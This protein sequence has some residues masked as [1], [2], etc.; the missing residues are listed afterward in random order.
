MLKSGSQVRVEI[1]LI[2][3]HTKFD[4]CCESIADGVL[5]NMW[6]KEQ[7]SMKRFLKNVFPSFLFIKIWIWMKNNNLGM[8]GG[9][10][11]LIYTAK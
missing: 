9:V 1:D 5:G 2:R 7:R 6:V 3:Q 4:L 8:D 10:G 11:K